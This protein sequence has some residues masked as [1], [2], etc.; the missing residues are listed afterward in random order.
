MKGREAPGQSAAES[1]VAAA[2]AS[3]ADHELLRRIGAGSYGEVW[4]ARNIMGE[5]RAVKI[6][7]RPGIGDARPFER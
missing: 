6:I 5:F 7:R 4:L 2:P 3:V 1:S